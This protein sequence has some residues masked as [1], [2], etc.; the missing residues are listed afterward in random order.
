MYRILILLLVSLIAGTG[1]YA[2]SNPGK[3]VGVEFEATSHDF[4]TVAENKGPVI[5]TY[6]FDNTGSSPVA[7]ITVATSCGCTRPEYTRKPVAPGEKGV[8]KVTFNTE[9]QRG[10]VNK[11]IKVRLRNAN[12]KAERVTLRLNGVVVPHTP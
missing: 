11:D 7:I 2:K 4:G 5:Y 9:G 8:I 10:E 1:T 3:K 12:G 6:T